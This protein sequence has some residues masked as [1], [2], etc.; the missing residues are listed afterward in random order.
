VLVAKMHGAGNDFVVVPVA[1]PEV[2]TDSELVRRLAD[3]RR[4][5][6]ADG[7]LFLERS[8]DETATFRMHFYN[9]DGGRAGLCLNGARCAA[10]RC[11]Q[12]GW[13]SRQVSIRTE[14]TLVHAEVD[15]D[16]GRVRLRLPRPDAE[17]RPVELP[18]GS[19]ARNGWA[20]DTGDPH[21]VV[22][23]STEEPFEERARPL[24]RWT[25]PNPAGS[26]VHFVVRQ[27]DEWL[28]RSFERGVEAETL[29]CGSGCVSALLALCGPQNGARARLRTRSGDRIDVAVREDQL[30]LEGPAVCVFT[31]EWSDDAA[32]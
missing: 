8:A 25:D 29:A 9:C 27:P 17:A 11:V 31:T 3:R 1:P 21:L 4:G 19:P 7:V 2:G 30:E 16:S 13:A 24:R 14:F 23:A 5:I 32:P 22:E 12:L 28:I 26:N 20:I 6:G 15:P 18:A 10:L